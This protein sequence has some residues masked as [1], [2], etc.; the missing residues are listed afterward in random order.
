MPHMVQPH[1]RVSPSWWVTLVGCRV[2]GPV[3]SLYTPIP[4]LEHSARLGS[5]RTC[6]YMPCLPCVPSARVRRFPDDAETAGRDGQFEDCV[7]GESPNWR[8]VR[9][10]RA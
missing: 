1:S 9:V 2:C 5:R 4:M 8:G 3:R 6:E 7:G 10:A